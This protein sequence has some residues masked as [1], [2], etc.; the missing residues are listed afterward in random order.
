MSNPSSY[1][2]NDSGRSFFD[3]PRPAPPP[4]SA[5]SARSTP[6][7]FVLPRI[8][9]TND[10]LFVTHDAHGHRVLPRVSDTP[11]HVD[12]TRVRRLV[13]FNP[14]PVPK[15]ASCAEMGVTCTFSEAGIPCPPC[16]VLGIPDCDW[17]DP[18]WLIENI[19]RCR[20]LYLLDERDG[21]VNS[22]KD[23]RL[24]PSL[25]EREFERIQTW[26]YAGAQG[27]ITRFSLNS[28]ATHDVA[29]RGYQA[30]ADASTDT[31]LL[32]RFLSLATK[33]HVHP[34]V[35]QI[36]ADRVQGIIASMMA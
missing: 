18:F 4:P 29:V 33:T 11:L 6:E 12:D 10:P 5:R 20:D 32:L 13:E 34:V 7:G 9:P 19:Q 24:A 26:F 17:T 15:C 22:V 31:T 28:R 25:F 21:L 2:S 23:N 16:A 3:H 36:V 1:D 8:P 14:A 35:L 30:L 27:A